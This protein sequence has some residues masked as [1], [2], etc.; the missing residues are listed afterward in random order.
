MDLNKNDNLTGILLM[1]G[2]MAG[3]AIEDMF[4]K[5]LTGALPTG[6]VLFLFG[7][8]GTPVFALMARMQ[9][10]RTFS[11]AALSAPLLWRNGG[12][13]AGTL[14]FIIAISLIPLAM[15]GSILQAMPLVV[16]AG[17]ALF[18]GEKV[19]WRRW[20]AI[21]LG[22]AGVLL[23]L[24][25]G[26]EGFRPEALWAVLAV[27]GLSVRDL[28]TRRV[29]ADISSMQV[30]ALGFLAVTLL[31]ALMMLVTGGALWPAP[32]HCVWL[33]LSL[34]FGISSYWAITAA[35]RL[36]DMSVITPFRYT[37]LL[38]VLIIAAVAFGER[39]DAPTLWGAALVIGSGLYTLARERARQRALSLA[40]A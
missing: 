3:F 20:T 7:L 12:E 19:G 36:G 16:T 13:M 9:G 5:W 26:L 2:S 1:V 39:P 34:V 10:E 27:L 30:G 40:R 4:T 18:M 25:P 14:G 33:T 15:V 21:G 38:F 31:G 22:F 17:A 11:R 29:A 28:A 35:M 24:R 8:L 37:R 32:L 6:E 23:I